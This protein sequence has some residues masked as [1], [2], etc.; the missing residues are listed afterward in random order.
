MHG[1]ERRRKRFATRRNRPPCHDRAALGGNVA[2][3]EN[4]LKTR[5]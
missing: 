4:G 1:L 3:A 2:E 5:S